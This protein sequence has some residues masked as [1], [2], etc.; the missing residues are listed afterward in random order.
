MIFSGMF[1]IMKVEFPFNLVQGHIATDSYK[2]TFKLKHP[3]FQTWMKGLKKKKKA[4]T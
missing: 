2:S 4:V 1:N 3:C